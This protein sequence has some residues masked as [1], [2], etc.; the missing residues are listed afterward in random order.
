MSALRSRWR[1]LQDFWAVQVEL[2]ERLVV[3]NRPWEQE[4]LHWSDGELHGCIQPPADGRRRSVT[5]GGWCAC[6]RISS[7]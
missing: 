1:A 7:P 2:Q 6:P 3:L 5:A 4:L